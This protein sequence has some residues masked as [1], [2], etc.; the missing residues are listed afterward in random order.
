MNDPMEPSS[1][2]LRA[3]ETKPS[4]GGPSFPLWHRLY[5]AL[6]ACVW[7]G[8]GQWTPAPLHGW[9]RLLL[10]SFGAK[11]DRKAK[12]YPN[13]TVWYPPHLSMDA[14]STLG[15]GVV[16]YCMAPIHLEPFALVSQRAHL[17][18]GTHDIDDP[19][20]QLQARPITIGSRA[21]VAAEAFVGPGVSIGN[22]AVL[23]ARAVAMKRLEPWT[24]YAGNPARPLRQRI[25]T[26]PE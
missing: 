9:R 18:A 19:D 24:V 4:D 22:G 11:I 25:H 13:V 15:P 12:V 7:L 21:W 8:L 5:R 17:C 10:V 2:I 26:E 14:Y 6:W 3:S 23:G 20:F 1:A 16:C